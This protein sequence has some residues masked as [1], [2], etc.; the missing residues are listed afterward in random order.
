[1]R[2]LGQT[3]DLE[4]AFFTSAEIKAQLA[5]VGS[6]VTEVIERE[7]YVGVEVE[8]RLHLC[9]QAIARSLPVRF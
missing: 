5:A 1:M 4:F 3:V 8:T 7:P 2:F 6:E 9:A